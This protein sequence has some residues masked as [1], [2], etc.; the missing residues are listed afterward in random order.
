MTSAQV[1][2]TS[3][4]VI[5]NSPSQ[6]YTHPDDRTLLYDMTPGF[7][8][9]TIITYEV[10]V[11]RNSVT[12]YDRLAG[13]GSTILCLILLLKTTILHSYCCR[14]ESCNVK[15][16]NTSKTSKEIHSGHSGLGKRHGLQVLSL[17]KR[18]R[19][20]QG[21]T[22]YG[23]LQMIPEVSLKTHKEQPYE[24]TS[25]HVNNIINHKHNILF[26]LSSA[27]ITKM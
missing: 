13:N 1:V 3:V 18:A 11:F 5:S 9:F 19:V 22:C 26:E 24:W 12:W 10:S 21:F 25:R 14:S 4:N 15:I 2:E 16:I 20:Q 8:P 17:W 6:D 7:K 27:W 23:I